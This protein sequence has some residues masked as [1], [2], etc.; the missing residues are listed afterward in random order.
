MNDDAEKDAGGRE[1]KVYPSKV[2]WWIALVLAG[3]VLF[4]L[5]LG[6]YLLDKD[7]TGAMIAIVVGL[8][9][10]VLIL[11]LTVPCR[12]TLAGDHLL[13]QAGLIRYKVMFRDIRTVARSSNPLSAPALSLQRVKIT[14]AKGFLLVSPADRDGFIAELTSR[15]Q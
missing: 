10:G 9:T 11:L 7:R 12:Y 2:D 14:L 8:L 13:V 6:V 1:V 5:G 4:S 3:S 15:V